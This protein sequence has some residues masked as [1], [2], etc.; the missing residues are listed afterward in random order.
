MILTPRIDVFNRFSDIKN[1]EHTIHILKYI[2]P[3]EFKLHNVFTSVVDSRE[4]TQPLKDYT[5]REHEI[6]TNASQYSSH[7]PKRLRGGPIELVRKMRKAHSK[8]PYVELLRYYCPA[9]VSHFMIMYI[10]IKKT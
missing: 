6:S 1:D 5:L 9:R 7:L 8:L 4:T 3:H 10:Y 2:F